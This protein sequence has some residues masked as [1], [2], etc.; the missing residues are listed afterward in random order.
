MSVCTAARSSTASVSD[1]A[2]GSA[3]YS[4]TTAP[5]ASSAT[6]ALVATTTATPSPAKHASSV[7]SGQCGGFTNSAV[8]FHAHGSGAA[9]SSRRSAPVNTPTTPTIASATE[10]S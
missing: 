9:N 2:A 5:A 10:A 6:V 4:T 8:T 7:A 3:S 1:T